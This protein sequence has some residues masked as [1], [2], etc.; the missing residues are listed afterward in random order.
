MGVSTSN[1]RKNASESVKPSPTVSVLDILKETTPFSGNNSLSSF[2]ATVDTS[3]EH[4]GL[5][6]D[7]GPVEMDP[8]VDLPVKDYRNLLSAMNEAAERLRR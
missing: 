4:V 2:G 3:I 1:Q 5:V 6:Q 7:S 8:V